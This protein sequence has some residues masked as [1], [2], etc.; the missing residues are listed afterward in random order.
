MVIEKSDHQKFTWRISYN[1][2]VE[3]VKRRIFNS[4][5]VHDLVENCQQTKIL[6]ANWFL[7]S[8]LYYQLNIM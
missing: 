8:S 2:L 1:N 7:L 3:E 4:L 5:T 6:Y